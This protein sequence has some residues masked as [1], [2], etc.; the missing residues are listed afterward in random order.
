MPG[1]W[2]DMGS[3]QNLKNTR[4]THAAANTHGD[5]DALGATAFAFDQGVTGQALPAD[6]V[7][8]SDSNR[9][10]LTLRRSFGMPSLSRQ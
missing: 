10:A 9:A 5:A 8:V 6:A 7:G 3:L 4:R 1:S 2:P